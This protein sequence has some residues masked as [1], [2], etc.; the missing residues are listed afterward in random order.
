[1]KYNSHHIQQC[2][3][4]LQLGLYDEPKVIYAQDV[5]KTA[6]MYLGWL[7]VLSAAAVGVYLVALTIYEAM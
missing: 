3:E 4:E 7:A 5:V 2:A 6:A 1:M